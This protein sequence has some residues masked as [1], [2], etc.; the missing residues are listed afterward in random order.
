LLLFALLSSPAA[1]QGRGL[2]II[3]RQDL[4]FGT[5]IPG[6]PVAVAPSSPA[7]AGQLEIRG[8]R[9]APVLL[10]FT[11][12]SALT[13]FGA[14]LPLSFVGGDAAFSADP[15]FGAAQFFDPR[16][17]QIAVLASNG[18][19]YVFL[20]GRVTPDASQPAGSY[21]ATITLT[22]SYVGN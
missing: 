18:K 7:G 8:R 14:S 3:P 16:T 21:G 4:S 2:S 11:L 1:A 6:V 10:D 17:A 19:L 15:A 12:P 5:V 13:A 22:V 9:N 20:G